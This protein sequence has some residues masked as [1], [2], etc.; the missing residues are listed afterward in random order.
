MTDTT[1]SE[2]TAP[3]WQVSVATRYVAGVDAFKG[4]IKRNGD[5]IMEKTRVI[6]AH[7]PQ[8]TITPRV[9]NGVR[10]LA[11]C[12][13][14]R[15]NKSKNFTT[16]KCRLLRR[17]F[18]N[19]NY[20]FRLAIVMSFA[21]FSYCAYQTHTYGV[22]DQ[23]PTEI[24]YLDTQRILSLIL[25]Y[26]MGTRWRVNGRLLPAGFLAIVSAM[27]FIYLSALV[28]QLEPALFL[29]AG[30]AG[31]LAC[32]QTRK[33]M[34]EN[35]TTRVTAELQGKKQ[36]GVRIKNLKDKTAKEQKPKK[37]KE[38]ESTQDGWFVLPAGESR[39]P[40]PAA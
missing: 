36:G 24:P 17:Y 35:I 16:R 9:C 13:K 22:Y 8:D 4:A 12:T 30:W 11:S 37:V 21:F 31:V 18:A 39:E 6:G 10:G 33:N 7:I 1:I 20:M 27:L 15:V 29:T 14:R 5:Y 25:A 32:K 3:Q 19:G 23:H 2:P 38:G 34:V 40:E 26:E 28:N